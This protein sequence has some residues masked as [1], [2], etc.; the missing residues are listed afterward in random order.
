MAFKNN[1]A[2]IILVAI[3]VLVITGL[4][5]A[6]SQKHEL[7]HI[8]YRELYFLPL[9]L[10]AFW[11]GLRGAFITSLCITFV[12]LTYTIFH[13]QSLSHND[14]DRLLEILLFN[15]VANG[16]GFLRN[17][18]K[19]IEKEKRKAIMAMASTVA[20]EINTPLFSAIGTSQLMQDEFNPDSDHHNDLQLIIRNLKEIKQMVKKIATIENPEMKTYVGNSVIIDLKKSVNPDISSN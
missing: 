16:L 4:H 12:Y 14:L 3:L 7:S 2:K 18:E 5:I 6:T 9:I 13:W 8:F 17:R 19:T 10:S 11:F 1:Q 15:I 20:H